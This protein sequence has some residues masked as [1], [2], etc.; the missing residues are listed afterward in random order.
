MPETSGAGLAALAQVGGQLT[1]SERLR[2]T[3]GQP[4]QL[5]SSATA[6]SAGPIRPARAGL[7]S[8]RPTAFRARA[9][10]GMTLTEEAALIC[11]IGAV[12]AMNLD[13]GGS[14]QFASDGQALDDPSSNPLRPV[15]DTI[16]VVPSS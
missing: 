8:R 4:F 14:T 7:F 12:N 13:G 3:Q 10:A 6:T 1:V 16:E 2:T 5:K 11:S 9:R 15:G